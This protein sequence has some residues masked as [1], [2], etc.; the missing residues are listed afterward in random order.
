MK[1]IQKT[2]Q[3]FTL[4]ELMIVVAIIGILAAVALPAYQNYTQRSANGACL[5]EARSYMGSAVADLALGGETATVAPAPNVACA[6]SPTPTWAQHTGGT[7]IVFTPRTR[8]NSA[9]LRTVSCNAGT[10]T[11]ELAGAPAGS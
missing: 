3:G 7:D 6:T 10:G 9:E 4:I 2:Q 8:G 5:G 1:S 11:C